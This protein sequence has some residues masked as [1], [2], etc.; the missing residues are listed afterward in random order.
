[1]LRGSPEDG[2]P[3]GLPVQSI[4]KRRRSGLPDRYLRTHYPLGVGDGSVANR[5][6]GVLS[7]HIPELLCHS[8]MKLLIPVQI[9]R[10]IRARSMFNGVLKR[11]SALRDTLSD[12]VF[13]LP[14]SGNCDIQ[15]N[16]PLRWV[17]GKL[18]LG[19]FNVSETFC[20]IRR[21]IVSEHECKSAKL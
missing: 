16:L 8:R 17:T 1:M 12:V 5:G 9:P 6:A 3:R 4:L 10:P 18:P 13:L 20:Y 14:P 21:G 2:T 11:I 15:G 7:H 19:S